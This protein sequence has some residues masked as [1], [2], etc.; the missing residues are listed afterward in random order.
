MQKTWGDIVGTVHPE[1]H[2]AT[3]VTKRRIRNKAWAYGYTVD[4]KTG[5]VKKG[6]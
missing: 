6:K 5:I 2:G 1:W 3:D 4:L